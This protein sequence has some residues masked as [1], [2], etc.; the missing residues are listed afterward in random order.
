MQNGLFL[1][2]QLDADLFGDGTCHFL[3]QRQG[4]SQITLIALC[5]K[6][7]VGG[8]ADQLCRDS[9]LLAGAQNCAFHHGIDV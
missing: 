9:N 5:P 2:S 1:W 4:V 3:L 6:M 7:L 8:S